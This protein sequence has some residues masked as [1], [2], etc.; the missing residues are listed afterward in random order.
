[1]DYP[2]YLAEEDA[3]IYYGYYADAEA[4]RD[5]MEWLLLA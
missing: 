2:E 3:D 5:Y 4:F 1:M